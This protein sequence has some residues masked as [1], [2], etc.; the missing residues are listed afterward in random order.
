MTEIVHPPQGPCFSD[1]QGK[2]AL[3]TGGGAGIGRGMSLR[4]A[5]EGMHVY[6]CGRT[7][8]T[9]LE[10]VDMIREQGGLAT[11]VLADVA[12]ED[13]VARVFTHIRG[14]QGTFDVLVHNAARV[15]SGSFEKTNADIWDD[16]FA[17]NTRSAFTLA[18]Q[19]TE[20]MIPKQSGSIIFIS[21]IGASR[22]HYN[23]V[24]YDSSKGAVDSFTRSLAIELARYRIRVNAI[25]PGATLG[26]DMHRKSKEFPWRQRNELVYEEEVPFEAIAQPYIPLGRYGTPA[27]IAA[28]VAFLASSQSSYVTG[29]IL[30]VDGGATA[31][32]SPRGIFI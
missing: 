22:G 9:L 5:A 4:L 16:V 20:L 29:Q 15:Q 24:A 19:A 14:E 6:I 1:L 21:T 11:S 26:R 25:A 7:E 32:L 12:N 8:E 23:M 28:A 2:I 10:T 30:N 31:Q 3:V 13:D 27:E 17:T 18:K